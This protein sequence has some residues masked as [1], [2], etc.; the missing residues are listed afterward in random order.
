MG[1]FE[2]KFEVPDL[3]GLKDSMRLSS[4]VWSG[5]RTHVADAVGLADKKLKKQDQHPLVRD[6]EKLLPS[7]TH[8]FRPGQTMFVYAELYDPGMVEPR[9]V[10]MVSAAV[11]VYREKKLVMES[12][13]VSVAA[14]KEGRAGTAG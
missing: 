1:T 9:N 8:V 12:A 13:P 2:S 3:G 4:V 6:K 14:L 5:Q 7:V 10:P 11:T